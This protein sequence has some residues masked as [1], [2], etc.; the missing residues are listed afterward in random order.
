MLRQP[1]PRALPLKTVALQVTKTGFLVKTS[2][3]EGRGER[4]TITDQTPGLGVAHF[5]NDIDRFPLPPRF[6]KDFAASRPVLS[7]ADQVT[8]AWG[9]RLGR[10]MRVERWTRSR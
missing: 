4:G 9:L 8:Q 10:R 5:P 6:L 7:I 3:I 2:G 1:N